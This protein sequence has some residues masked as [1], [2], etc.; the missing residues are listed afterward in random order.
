MFPCNIHIMPAMKYLKLEKT[1]SVTLF[2]SLVTYLSGNLYL[3]NICFTMIHCQRKTD[4]KCLTRMIMMQCFDML[5]IDIFI[6]NI[7]ARIKN[8]RYFESLIS[9]F[10]AKVSLIFI[11]GK[12]NYFE[13]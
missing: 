6:Y 4:L 13:V 11:F 2:Y 1:K 9:Y 3:I 7:Q 12:L 5:C 8:Y 10:Y